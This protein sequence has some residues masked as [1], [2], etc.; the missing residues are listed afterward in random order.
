MQCSEE[1][2]VKANGQPPA[3]AI[4]KR[5]RCLMFVPIALA[6]CSMATCYRA[7]GCPATASWHC[8]LN[9][10]FGLPWRTDKHLCQAWRDRHYCARI[11][12]V[13]VTFFCLCT[14]VTCVDSAS[15]AQLH[16]AQAEGQPL[17]ART[18]LS[19][20]GMTSAA[21]ASVGAGEYHGAIA[22]HNASDPQMHAMV[23]DGIAALCEFILIVFCMPASIA[24]C[25]GVVATR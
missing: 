24:G 22:D 21:A 14:C 10:N 18:L 12:S 8:H 11:L 1:W 15:R 2:R 4:S 25:P 7:V 3:R 5:V 19:C 17:G 6:C 13:D 9:S 16:A 20:S 23:Q